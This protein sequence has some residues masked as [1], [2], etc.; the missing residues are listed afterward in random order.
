MAALLAPR[1]RKAIGQDAALQVLPQLR[2]GVRRDA[3]IFPVVVA[4]GKEG[5]EM[6][7]Y[8]TVE[9]CFGGASPTVNAGRSAHIL[10]SSVLVAVRP[11]IG[12]SVQSG[13]S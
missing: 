3:L 10:V 4:Q 8:R 6:V 2:L 9:R 13:L 12:C 1:S 11:L 5:L 7:W